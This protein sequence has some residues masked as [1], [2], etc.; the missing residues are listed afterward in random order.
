M[1]PSPARLDI[2]LEDLSGAPGVKWRGLFIGG[3]SRF[4]TITS[5]RF[6]SANRLVCFSLLG[7][8]AYLIEFDM[9][10]Q[11]WTILDRIDTEYQGIPCETDLCDTD[12]TGYIATSNCRNASV[13]LYRQEDDR[14]FHVRDLTFGTGYVHG[15]SF[16]TPETLAITVLNQEPG[17][18]IHRTDTAE[19]LLY[20]PLDYRAKDAC[21]VR[22]GRLALIAAHG[23]PKKG[24]QAIYNSEIM[25][26]DFDLATGS[27]HVAAQVTVPDDQFDSCLVHEGVLF[28]T[29]G[30]T[31]QVYRHD[32]ETLAPLDSLSGYDCPHGIDIAHGLLA[33]SNYGNTSVSIRVLP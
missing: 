10:Q 9:N 21:L 11:S 8:K 2:Q 27:Y 23:A 7:K 28:S 32:A 18:H 14:I 33:V 16:L 29:G 22:D 6:I 25:L 31:N 13:S 19:R 17:L 20:M 15:V 24:E 3:K 12:G 26:V 1:T 5:V 4:A 30:F